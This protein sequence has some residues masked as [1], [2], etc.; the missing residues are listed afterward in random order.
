MGKWKEFWRGFTLLALS[1]AFATA[2]P[3]ICRADD[4]GGIFDAFQQ[5]KIDCNEAYGGIDV[6]PS[7]RAPVGHAECILKCER[8]FWKNMDR[9][10][11]QLEKE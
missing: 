1:L 6:F 5:C 2:I 8:Q 7:K 3:L 9:K 4:D 11:R 10:N